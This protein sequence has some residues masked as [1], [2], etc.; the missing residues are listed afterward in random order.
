MPNRNTALPERGVPA[1]ARGMETQHIALVRTIAEHG[2][3]SGAA[4]SLG[5]TQPA[6]T[7]I[8]SRVEDLMGAKL[9]DRNPRGVTLTPFGELFLARMERVEDEMQALSAEIRSRKQGLTGTVSVGVGQFWLGRILPNVILR[10]TASAPGVQV[11]IR[12]GPREEL[13]QH[14]R[15]GGTDLMLGRITDDLPD[16]LVGEPVARVGMYLIARKDHPLTRLG[17]DPSRAELHECGWILPPSPD[18]TVRY[19]FTDF[20]LEPPE[21]RVEALSRHLVFDLLRGSDMV[22]IMPDLALDALPEGLVRLNADWLG[23][24]RK[25]GVIRHAGRTMLPCVEQFL[26]E[27]RAET[28]ARR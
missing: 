23:W 21:P 10:L 2:N 26:A 27:L 12:T 11:R 15:D 6:L 25:A 9:F 19:A 20:D 24:S 28:A 8:V 3:I 18:P 22:S 5:L 17:R 1:Y 13:I 7:K 16:G 14:L 4:R